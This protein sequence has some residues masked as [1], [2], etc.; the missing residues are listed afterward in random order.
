VSPK[1]K[2][3]LGRVATLRSRLDQTATKRADQE[4]RVEEIAREQARIRENMMRVPQ[5]SE[6]HAR[7]LTSLGQQETEIESLRKEIASLRNTERAQ[8]RELDEYLM[9]LSIE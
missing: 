8:K 7:Y 5:N 9:S 1:V 2:E 6:L 4:K 3:A